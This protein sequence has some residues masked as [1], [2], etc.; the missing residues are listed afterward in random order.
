VGGLALGAV[1]C[2]LVVGLD[3][4]D[5][6]IDTVNCPGDASA[7]ADAMTVADT[8]PADTGPVIVPSE[9]SLANRWAHWR[10]PNPRDAET[11]VNVANY[12]VGPWALEAGVEGG[13]PMADAG[14]IEV[15]QDTL[16]QKVWAK[17][18]WLGMTYAEANARCAELAAATGEPFRL[19][20]RIELV[21]ILDYKGDPAI[22]PLFE[23]K[24]K[25]TFWTQSVAL[26]E[27]S[28]VWVVNFAA[29]G[30]ADIESNLTNHAAV[31]CV[32]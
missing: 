3:R 16:T 31:R 5:K 30:N 27:T 8:G 20:T 23:L 7:D 10:M 26:G 25:T 9:A 15:V 13:L 28:G 11:D 22:D 4:F 2:Q 19:P 1:A 18:Y 32:R 29:N 24:D 6:C 21:S 12:L 14:T 17:G